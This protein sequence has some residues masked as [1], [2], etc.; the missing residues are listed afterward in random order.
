MSARTGHIP[1]RS[2]KAC[3]KRKAQ[4]E[5]QRWVLGI[6]NQPV[7]DE[8]KKSSGRGAYVCSQD[9]YNKV[10]QHLPRILLRRSNR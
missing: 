3:R 9:C 5:L 1:I 10:S 8:E 4:N 7:A 2:C 6:D